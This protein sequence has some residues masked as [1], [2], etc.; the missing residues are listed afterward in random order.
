MAKTCPVTKEKVLYLECLECED[1]MC[2][3]VQKGKEIEKNNAGAEI[4]PHSML[5][6][7][8]RDSERV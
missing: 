2:R 5:N 7:G 3:T 4:Q 8:S 6:G 1:K